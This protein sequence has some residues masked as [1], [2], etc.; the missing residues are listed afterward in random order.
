MPQEA[1]EVLIK[2]SAKGAP[3]AQARLQQEVDETTNEIDDALA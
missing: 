1:D 3:A 2:K